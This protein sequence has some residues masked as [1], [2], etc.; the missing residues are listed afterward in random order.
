M[1]NGT[2]TISFAQDL[3]EDYL[4]TEEKRRAHLRGIQMQSC[5]G[6]ICIQVQ[7]VQHFY[8]NRAG[9]WVKL[10]KRGI[11]AVDECAAIVSPFSVLVTLDTKLR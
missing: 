7:G 11:A 5:F 9:G 4:D 10:N 1:N 3:L 6:V 8:E 2:A